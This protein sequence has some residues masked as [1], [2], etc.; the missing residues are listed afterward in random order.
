MIDSLARITFP[1]RLRRMR[2]T[3]TP[4]IIIFFFF[5]ACVHV[6]RVDIDRFRNIASEL[7]GRRRAGRMKLTNK[8]VPSFSSFSTHAAH[9]QSDHMSNFA[10]TAAGATIYPFFLSSSSFAAA[11]AAA[12]QQSRYVLYIMRRRNKLV[13]SGV[14]SYRWM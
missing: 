10:I 9:P 3:E 4:T 2:C 7:Q 13:L 14:I 8:Q 5:H 1:S 12:S 6:C 11:A